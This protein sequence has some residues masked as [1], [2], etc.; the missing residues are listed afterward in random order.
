MA[1]GVVPVASA[2]GSIPQSLESIGSGRA[3]PPLDIDAFAEAV[4]SYVDS[5]ESWRRESARALGAAPLF[6]YSRY[7]A[8]VCAIMGAEAE[9]R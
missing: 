3:L 4:K 5:P 9:V 1:H 8:E 2:V 7:L 6:T